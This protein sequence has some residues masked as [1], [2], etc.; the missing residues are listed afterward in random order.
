M[1]LQCANMY[2]RT[3]HSNTKYNTKNNYL[4]AWH[5]RFTKVNYDLIT[6]LSIIITGFLTP[7]CACNIIYRNISKMVDQSWPVNPRMHYLLL[8]LTSS[9]RLQLYPNPWEL[10]NFKGPAIITIVDPFM[11]R[12]GG[13]CISSNFHQ[14]FSSQVHYTLINIDK[15]T[16]TSFWQNCYS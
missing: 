11:G 3:G 13:G 4:Y 2:A 12:V 16:S 14:I 7:N 15:V 8:T 5:C 6:Q 10:C 1:L 9:G